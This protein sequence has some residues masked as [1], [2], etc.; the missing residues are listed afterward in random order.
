MNEGFYDRIDDAP[1]EYFIVAE[2]E[3]VPFDSAFSINGVEVE[4][5]STICEAP[6]ETGIKSQDHMVVE[7]YRV[8]VTGHT[9]VASTHR[10]LYTLFDLQKRGVMLGVETPDIY[11]SRLM[12]KSCKARYSPDKIDLAEITIVLQKI[13]FVEGDETP[14]S[15]NEEDSQTVDGG[16]ASVAM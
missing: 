10:I 8:I 1:L 7:P 11:H 16:I 12:V 2:A 3:N 13:L 15:V 4:S 9:A 14:S 5:N 6:I